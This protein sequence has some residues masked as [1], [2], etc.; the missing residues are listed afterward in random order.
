MRLLLTS[1][2]LTNQSIKDAM[3][4]LA[5]KPAEDLH[6]VFIPTA[7]NPENGTGNN[8]KSWLLNYLNEAKSLNP[9]VLDIID[10]AVANN[11][12]EARIK[13]A[14]VIIVGGGNT[15][16]LSYW[17]QKSG[18]M[19]AL[20]ELVK[21]KVYVGISAGSM[22]VTPTLKV[23]SQAINKLDTVQEEELDRLGPPGESSAATAS[24]VAFAVR[25]HFGAPHRGTITKDFLQTIAQAINLPIYAIDDQSA[26]KV[27]DENIEI[28]SEGTWTH[29]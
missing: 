15:F 22:I 16:Y 5:Q 13:L 29:L 6:I 23:T 1:N 25:P 10:L 7:A 24:L 2:G 28:I 8:D 21:T 11:D 12:W 26:V 18:F 4:D 9:K 17:M 19:D 3:I 14:D 27:I 20:P